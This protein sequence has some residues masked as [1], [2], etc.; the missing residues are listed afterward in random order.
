MLLDTGYLSA[1]P[2]H[3]RPSGCPGSGHAEGHADLHENPFQALY[4]RT[5]LDLHQDDGAGGHDAAPGALDNMDAMDAQ[6]LELDSQMDNKNLFVDAFQYF[7]QDADTESSYSSLEEDVKPALV[8]G[9]LPHMIPGSRRFA[10]PSPPLVPRLEAPSVGRD[11]G[12]PP[13]SILLHTGANVVDMVSG[14]TCSGVGLGALARFHDGDV[15]GD[16]TRTCSS[17]DQRPAFGQ[18]QVNESLA[19]R[20]PFQC[21]VQTPADPLHPQPSS[22][23]D[24]TSFSRRATSATS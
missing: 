14:V 20:S 19:V 22:A 3:H 7:G 24:D 13:Q 6:L 10:A 5:A 18:H 21:T 4:L 12:Q 17:M 15:V 1:A 8:P 9:G 23:V 11:S 2:L 16:L